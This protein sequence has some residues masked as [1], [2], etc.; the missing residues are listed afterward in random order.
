LRLDERIADAAYH[1]GYVGLQV[2]E[3]MM[4]SEFIESTSGSPD[5]R[6]WSS[7]DGQRWEPTAVW[8]CKVDAVGG[9]LGFF[10]HAGEVYF[11]HNGA[12]KTYLNTTVFTINGPALLSEPQRILHP[13]YWVDPVAGTD[14]MANYQGYRPSGPW[15]KLQ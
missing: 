14:T 4:F 3:N 1:A 2:G 10:T 11:T 9:T 8:N 13:V 15:K 5:V 6:L 12:G 7:T